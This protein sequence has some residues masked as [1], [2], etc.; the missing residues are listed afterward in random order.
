MKSAFLPRALGLYALHILASHSP[1]SLLN[2]F[3]FHLFLVN[4]ICFPFPLCPSNLLA[5]TSY[6]PPSHQS[7]SSSTSFYFEHQVSFPSLSPLCMWFIPISNE[8]KTYSK[9][10]QQRLSI[11]NTKSFYFLLEWS[12][13]GRISTG[14]LWKVHNSFIIILVSVP[15]VVD[16]TSPPTANE[17]QWKVCNLLLPAEKKK[18]DRN[19][20][21]KLR[22]ECA[23][24][25]SKPVGRV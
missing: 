19:I 12:N 21:L 13:F 14:I 5:T 24:M 8:S 10:S 17:L 1:S 11:E 15:V 25:N 22:V 23:S 3:P 20:H 18:S 4:S 2:S 16:V 7:P 9:D 6:L